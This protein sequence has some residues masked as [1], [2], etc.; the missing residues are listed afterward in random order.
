M[1][2]RVGDP[3]PLRGKLTVTRQRFAEHLEAI[4]ERFEVVSLAAIVAGLRTGVLRSGSVAVTFDDGYAD[5][6][7][8]AKPLL[9]RFSIP[10]TVFIVSGYVGAEKRFWWMS[11]NASVRQH[12]RC[13]AGSS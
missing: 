2:H 13:P 8:E 1:Y 5:N 7:V 6:L 9:E 11:W 10:A 3:D 12:R 4:A